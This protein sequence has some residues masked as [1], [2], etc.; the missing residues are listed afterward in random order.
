[1]SHQQQLHNR[2]FKLYLEMKK[3]E[4]TL[5]VPFAKELL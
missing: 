2:V 3:D 1:M 4:S 5:M